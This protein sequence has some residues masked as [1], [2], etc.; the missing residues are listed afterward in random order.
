MIRMKFIGN[1][2][3]EEDEVKM[4]FFNTQLIEMAVKLG[5]QIIKN[6]KNFIVFPLCF[7]DASYNLV[8]C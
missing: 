7:C 8:N 2:K 6:G 5:R 1:F 3:F 4:S